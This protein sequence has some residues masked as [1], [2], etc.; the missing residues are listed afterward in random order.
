MADLSIGSNFAGHRIVRYGAGGEGHDLADGRLEVP[1][2]GHDL[3]PEVA[4]GEDPQPV[5]ARDQQ[6]AMT[7]NG[8]Q[9]QTE[10]APDHQL[11]KGPADHA[12]LP[13]AMPPSSDYLAVSVKAR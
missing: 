5:V 6:V 8:V 12:A 4:I 1:A 11:P 13:P 10:P 2:R 3:R 9:Q 7:D